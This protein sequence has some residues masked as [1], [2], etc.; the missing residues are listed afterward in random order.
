MNI[1]ILSPGR[2]VDIVQYFKA[3]IHKEGGKVF[4]VD[5]S[6]Y[7]PGLYEG[8]ESFVVKKDFNDLDKYID[9]VIEICKDNS[10][11]AIITLIDPE[12]VLLAK[13]KDKFINNGI[14]PIL[15][16]YE[17]IIFTF[18]KYNFAETLKERLP[19]IKTYN[20][21]NDI[22]LA[23]ENNNVKFP[24]FAK[25]REG[26]GSVGIGRISNYEDLLT[27]KEKEN[28]IF[29]PYVKEREFGVDVYFDFIDGKIKS[30]FIKEKLNMRAGET[31]KSV[32]V[33]REDIVD[34]ILKLQELK[35]KGPIDVDIFEDKNG[36][37]YINEINPR[38]GG[39]YP[40]AYNSGVNFIKMI[41]EN[42]KGNS[43]EECV[44]N[45]EEGIIMMKYNGIKIIKEK[46]LRVSQ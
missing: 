19:V 40:H 30:L 9:S 41:I 38:F 26:S 31:D 21:Y 29:Q 37:L 15:S 6:P 39:G 35:F 10:I 7:A 46:D 17:E 1:M 16:N 20:G 28:Y 25:E 13:N 23:L 42:I 2:R 22:R 4:T 27:Y 18:D 8:D 5:M 24:L 11:K 33:Y 34:L 32:S 45:Y 3:E 36:E 43:C 14:L 12:L 44:G